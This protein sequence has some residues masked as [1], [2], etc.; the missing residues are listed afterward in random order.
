MK[1]ELEL[2]IW[3][4]GKKSK[5][6]YPTWLQRFQSLNIDYVTIFHTLPNPKGGLIVRDI[7][8]IK[9]EVDII[10]N[11]GLQPKLSYWFGTKQN[12]LIPNVEAI[13]KVQKLG[14]G[15]DLLE[16]ELDAEFHT[17]AYGLNSAQN[18]AKQIKNEL[19]LD[20]FRKK[21]GMTYIPGLSPVI[22]LLM[23]ELADYFSSFPSQMYSFFNP[24]KQ[25]QTAEDIFRPKNIQNYGISAFQNKI[26]SDKQLVKAYDNDLEQLK[27]SFVCALA[28]YWQKHPNYRLNNGKYDIQLALDDAFLT[29]FNRGYRRFCFFSDIWLF[30]SGDPEEREIC[31]EFV[32]GLKK[33]FASEETDESFLELKEEIKIRKIQY[34]LAS[35]GYNIGNYGQFGDG[36]DGS[37]GKMTQKSM[38]EAEKRFNLKQDGLPDEVL[39]E[40]LNDE[41]MKHYGFEPKFDQKAEDF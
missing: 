31:R 37:N 8:S 21:L 10:L 39:F 41:F 4:S 36:V 22:K 38:K 2:G 32:A 35:L 30:D 19:E 29:C 27:R 7:S 33:R 11:G 3:T 25:K 9:R 23:E 5:L 40:K 26:L 28:V 18:A 34:L 12:Y 24:N 17:T 16:Y 1:N 15:G 6:S 14:I 20:K 13:K